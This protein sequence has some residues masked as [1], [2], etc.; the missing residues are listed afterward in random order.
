MT[1]RFQKRGGRDARHSP[2]RLG[3]IPLSALLTAALDVWSHCCVASSLQPSLLPEPAFSLACGGAGT[4]GSADWNDAKSGLIVRNQVTH[5]ADFSAIEWRLEIQQAGREPSPMLEHVQAGDFVLPCPEGDT[6]T[7]HYSQGSQDSATDFLPLETRLQPGQKCEFAPRDGRSSDGVMPYFNLARQAGGGWVVAV[8]WTGQ[9]QAMFARASN[10]PVQVR[11]GQQHFRAILRPGERIRTPAVLAMSYH[12]DW[13]DGQN[14]FRRLMLA[15]F[16][17]RPAGKPVELPV[18]ASGACI[19]FNSF[20]ESNQLM[21]LDNVVAKR[22]PVDTWW[23]DAGWMQ[24]GFPMGQGNFDPDPQRFPRGMRPVADRAHA[25]GLRFLLWFEP[26]RVMPGTWLRQAHE[27][28]LLSP[29]ALPARLQ[30]QDAW[31]LLNLGHPEALG[32]LKTHV[33]R[34][35]G[36]WGVDVYRHDCN[37]HPAFYWTGGDAPDRVGVAEARYI[38]GLYEFF[39]F[40]R[41]QHPQLLID[42]CASGGRRLDF[43]MMRRSVVLWR[44]DHCWQPEPDQSKTYGLSLWLPLQGLGAV[45]TNA[46][47]F[48][49]G[50][51]SCAAYALNFYSAQEPFWEPLDRLIREQRQVR[52]L[53][54]GDFYPLTPCGANQQDL[55]AWQFHRPDLGEGLVQTFRR[56]AC[57][58]PSAQFRFRGLVPQA[59]YRVATLGTPGT[60][61]VS[62]AELLSHGLAVALPQV[63]QAVILTYTRQTASK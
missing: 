29:S 46:Y 32:W 58:T 55:I 3:R 26:E 8:G 2:R 35:I 25:G 27:A 47:V 45:S 30:Y 63:P 52:H 17:P 28:W 42:N 41:E 48:R 53:F 12:G 43:E 44:S 56:P 54:A 4:R 5:Y 23:V 39:D 20:S 6:L 10:G 16:T 14:Q 62:G 50:M 40:L 59:S 57:P 31:R 21:A 61:D 51:G 11:V 22:L 1:C 36:E 19:P 15:H 49:S 9:W 24:G 37:I 13:L 38:T 33:S 7:M 60:T 34:L 18:A